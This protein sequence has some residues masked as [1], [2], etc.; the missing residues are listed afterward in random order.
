MSVVHYW[1]GRLKERQP[2]RSESLR[3]E[4]VTVRAREGNDTWPRAIAKQTM[5][6]DYLTWFEEVYL[7]P[8]LDSG[9]YKDCPQALPQP[10]DDLHFFTAISPFVYLLGKHAQTRPYR[11][12]EQRMHEDRWVTIRVTRNFVRLCEWGDHV[13]AFELA[14]GLLVGSRLPTPDRDHMFTVAQSVKVTINKMAGNRDALP[15]AMRKP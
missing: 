15:A 5:R 1:H 8:Y 11:V 9:Y 12:Q 13:A 6:N 14:T 4:G 2:F 3:I 7:P 10:L